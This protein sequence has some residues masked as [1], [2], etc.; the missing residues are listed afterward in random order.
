MESNLGYVPTE[1]DNPNKASAGAF[2]IGALLWGGLS[3]LIGKGIAKEMIKW[4]VI[5]EK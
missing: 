4:E 5:Y 3:Y 2:L 1:V